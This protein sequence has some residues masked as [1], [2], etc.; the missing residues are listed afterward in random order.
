MQNRTKFMIAGAS[1]LAVA[2]GGAGIAFGTGGDDGAGQPITG[3]A[4][5]KASAAALDA[6]GG[7]TVTATEFRDEEGYYEVEVTRNDGSQLD[8]H[9]DRSFNVSDQSGDGGGADGEGES[10]AGD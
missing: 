5:E 7:G 9:L 3:A 1:A 2:A 10:S 8:V 6:A 4:L